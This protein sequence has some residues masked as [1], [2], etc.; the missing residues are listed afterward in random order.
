MQRRVKFD[1]EVDF[2]NGGGVQG[3]DF[4]LDILADDLTDTAL[5]DAIV[6]ELSLLM[7]GHTRILKKRDHLGAAQ[8]ADCRLDF[9][10]RA[11]GS[12]PHHL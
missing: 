9:A 1:F 3:Q 2:T 11:R 5:A 7:V 6:R 4:R 10:R 8:T 12:E